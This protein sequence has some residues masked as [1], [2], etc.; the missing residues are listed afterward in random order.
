MGHFMCIALFVQLCNVVVIHYNH[1]VEV[2]NYVCQKF[3]L[4]C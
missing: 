3:I 4:N 2:V 1:T